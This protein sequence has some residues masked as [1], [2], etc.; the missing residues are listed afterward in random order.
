MINESP[1][2][3][4]FSSHLFTEFINQPTSKRSRKQSEGILEEY[5]S[6]LPSGRN[7]EKQ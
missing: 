3:K 7:K 4:T 5:Q 1:A 2:P 6:K